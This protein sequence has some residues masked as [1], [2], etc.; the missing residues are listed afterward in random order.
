MQLNGDERAVGAI[1][2]IAALAAQRST[3]EHAELIARFA[4][5]YLHDTDVADLENRAID[6]LY[7]AVLSHWNLGFERKA[8][9]A[10][11]ALVNPD[12][13]TAGWRSPHTVV[14]IVTDDAPFLVDSVRLVLNRHD[15][16]I[17]LMIHP[18][19][20]VERGDDGKVLAL[21]DEGGEI[22]AWTLVE[23]DRCDALTCHAI[24]SELASVLAD[25]DQAVSDWAEMAERVLVLAS[26]VEQRESTDPRIAGE[27]PVTAGFLRWLIDG[28]FVLL[29][30]ASYRVDAKGDLQLEEGSGL[31][32]LTRSHHADPPMTLQ[33]RLLA[34]SRADARSS[35]H[36]AARFTC[37][38]VRRFDETGT[39]VGED[40][41]IG[42]FA[43]S[44][45]R[46]SVLDTP[47]LRERAA[48]VLERSGFMADA[49]SGREL[50]AVLEAFPRDELFETGA[51]E[52]Y[53][54]ALG[55]IGLQ[56]RQRVRIFSL[57]EPGDRYVSCLVYLPRSRFTTD[58]A[59]AIA[60]MVKAAFDGSEAEHDTS[61]GASALARVH[62]V[63]RR[64]P[65]TRTVPHLAE[66]EARIDAFTTSWAERLH[67]ELVLAL[68][69]QGAREIAARIDDEIPVEYQ[70]T[71]DPRAAVADLRRLLALGPDSPLA[72]ALQ[73]RLDD[74]ANDL[75][76]KL[77]RRGEPITL[78]AVLPL[79]ENLG[80]AV[81]DERPFEFRPT[82]THT[83]WVYDIGIR[84]PDGVE[85]DEA[86]R[87][88]FQASFADLFRGETENDGLNRLVLVGGM[89][90]RQVTVIRAYVKYLR[91]TG[92]PFSQP[93]IESTLV[94]HAST[95]KAL[96]ELFGIR[97]DP[98]LDGDRDARA[99]AAHVEL[100][101]ALDA[102]PSL[103][104]D[105]ILRG[106][107]ALIDAT[108]RTNAYRPVGDVDGGP[109]RPVIA[110]K[111]DPSRIPDL[112]LPRPMF[113]IFVCSPR[114][115][116][117]HLRGG[118]IARGG[119]RWSDR[120]ED[121]R[122]EILGLMKAQTVKNSVIVPVGAKG[123]FVVKQPPRG[124]DELWA[125]VVACYRMFVAGLLDVT[126]NIVGSGV[127]PPPNTVRY[128]GDDAY[129]VV[130]AD[131]G[132]ATFSDVANEIAA[133]YGFW[134][135]DAFASGGSVGY[136]H[137]SMA[138]TARGAWESVR[139][140]ARVLGKD[141]D[142]DEL[143]VVGI[144]DMS[145]DVFGNGMLRSPHV[146]LVAAFDHRHVFLD[147]DP[148][149]AR[150]YAE[151]KRLFE[152][153]RS[154]W[155]DY[156]PLV[157]SHG[158]GV[159][160]RS[161]KVIELSPE[162]RRVLDVDAVA[163]AP[164]ELLSAI[165]RSPVD[166]LWNGG[167]G[168]YVKA[169]T[170]THGDAGDRAN[171]SLRVAGAE[172][173]CK[174]VG[175]G[176]NLGFTQ[177]GR[178]E[179]A[180]RGGLINTDAIDNSAGVDCS[181]HEVNIK[182]LLNQLVESGDLTVKQ[183]NELLASM[184]DEVGEL[185]LA[186]NEAQTL[187]LAIARVQAAAMVNVHGRYIQQLERE[188]W[189][190]REL[191]FIPNEKQLADRAAAGGGLTTPEFAVL[192]AYTK[193]ADIADVSMT[194]L[195]DDSYLE[196]ELVRYFPR[197]IRERFAGEIL[198]HRL[199]RE[200]IVTQLVN[201]MVNLSGIS[202][203]HRM[204]EET[205]AVTADV[206]RAWIAARDI[207]GFAELW[208]EIESIGGSIGLSTQ[209]GLSLD[210]RRMVERGVIWLLRH[211]RP[212]LPLRE[213]VS[214]FRP[215]VE[216][217][218]DRLTPLVRGPLAE[219]TT[220]LAAERI[221]AGVPADLAER[222]AIWPLM[223]TSFDLLELS[224][225]HGCSAEEAASAYWDLFEHLRVTWLWNAI[226][227]LP[228]VD[229]WQ[230]HARAAVRDDLLSALADLAGDV[231]A[232]GGSAVQWAHI[233]EHAIGRAREVFAEIRRGGT[234]DLTTLSVALRQ[235]RNLVLS[236]APGA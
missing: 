200:I 191:E 161:A 91:Q 208:E 121:F 69:E 184:T 219:Q 206:L 11:V 172:L 198:D 48:E 197:A 8:G 193:M 165:L 79:L 25:V 220:A 228:R 44:A 53:H 164:N 93:T 15:L 215:G 105:R 114:V 235:L 98:R 95:T 229:R 192:L 77:Y 166:L 36:R 221:V 189:L 70:A 63:V 78:S 133:A 173:R 132:T 88:E 140:H 230:T 171:D 232:H 175:E 58:V 61:V 97:F 148:D 213:T 180:L 41:I 59:D 62:V 224:E 169:S 49:H 101:Q 54:L 76:F 150:S 30:M 66:L 94:R 102:V 45:Y 205:G 128:D 227:M 178:V 136:D 218:F 109:L 14:M 160:P 60:R 156:D 145:G 106:I 170:E 33:R 108:T 75:R 176:G 182:I 112:P 183:R 211:R 127:V 199:R 214:A 159:Y 119:L 87:A 73:H 68:G 19:I 163:L 83:A 187:A 100:E 144:G 56:E 40:R 107:L 143:T 21:P 65:G 46:E 212:P 204:T 179:Y 64:S 55:I 131:K 115:E 35:V 32:L 210:L 231:L 186:D 74:D 226:G 51:D 174:M 72:T 89:T 113:E 104:D 135:G 146:K 142:H 1:D 7:G 16:G 22:E 86:R 124:G 223:H 50:R 13:D 24:E 17:H 222:S 196:P 29:G 185:V 99:T 202:F 43:A 47:V 120:R 125:E 27:I 23:I 177:R 126:D 42:L 5:C 181:D 103:D 38:A 137:K 194:T 3:P 167:I 82:S 201:Q 153:P 20:R 216:L 139:R 6:D 188:G 28:R 217:L 2:R 26:D 190:N 168:T 118:R 31:G 209:L 92:F 52:L 233:N 147:P 154:S 85:V 151:R 141:A 203:D 134:L 39:I 234:L 116:G 34:I 37:I 67:A 123:G 138:I 157:I 84:V 80:V 12:M 4:R 18:M 236:T 129:L 225:K 10:K 96:A 111:L 81:V 162:V 110:F 57:S 152:L 122:T 71:T 149:P 117:V 195:A 90:G 158:G 155:A 130:A 207:F 9:A